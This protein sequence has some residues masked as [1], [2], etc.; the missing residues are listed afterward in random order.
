MCSTLNRG[1]QMKSPIYVVANLRVSL[2]FDLS[3]PANLSA[4]STLENWKD[5]EP[6]SP[7]SRGISLSLLVALLHGHS[8][9]KPVYL[10]FEGLSSKPILDTNAYQSTIQ[11]LSSGNGRSD[12]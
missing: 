11:P 5:S 7:N 6:N 2:T 9:D 3:D 1:R 4:V 10:K 12:T 8:P